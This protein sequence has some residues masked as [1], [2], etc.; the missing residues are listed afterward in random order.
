ML[1]VSQTRRGRGWSLPTQ[2]RT[3]QLFLHVVI[4][5]RGNVVLMWG[6]KSGW[7]RLETAAELNHAQRHSIWGMLDVLG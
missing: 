4:E 3:L 7:I 6:V 5:R 1:F 2:R